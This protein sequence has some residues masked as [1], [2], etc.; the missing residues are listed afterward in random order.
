MRHIISCIVRNQPG[1]LAEV[2]RCLA[3][4]TIN[5][6]SLAV[7]ESEGEN[8]SRMTVVVLCKQDTLEA[9]ARE[10]EQIDNVVEVENLVRIGFLDREL[11]LVKVSPQPGDMPRL[12]QVLEVM[13]AGV[14][15]MG[16]QTLTVEMTGT[17]ERIHALLRLLKPFGIREYARS[18][19]AAVSAG[20]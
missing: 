8:T 13:R 12:M 7:T 6:H 20:D 17:E 2:A 5:I 15:A 14:A 4:R 16:R 11:V 1:V 10:L 18:G 9:A 3:Q 19:L